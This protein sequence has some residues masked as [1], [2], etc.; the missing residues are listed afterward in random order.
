MLQSIRRILLWYLQQRSMEDNLGACKI[1]SLSSEG[2]GIGEFEGAAI[3]VPFTLPGE[4][5]SFQQFGSKRR[6]KFVFQSVLQPSNLRIEPVCKHFTHCGGCTLQHM[7]SSLYSEFKKSLITIP[8]QDQGLDPFIVR[9]IV[10]L[11]FGQRR[12]SNIEAIKK[13]DTVFLG[14]HRWRGH[15]IV[16]LTECHTLSPHLRNLL[17]PLR[18][19]LTELLEP[20]QKAKIFLTQTKVGV[21]LSLEIQG[22]LQLNDGQ[23]ET[24]KNFGLDQNLARLIFKHG[25]KIDLLYQL[26][27]PV[28]EF[29]GVE[30]AV[31]AYGF[32][33]ATEEADRVLSKFVVEAIPAGVQKIADLFCG[34]GTF[35]FPLSCISPVDAYEFDKASLLALEQAVVKS[36]REVTTVH[37]NLYDHPLTKAELDIYD[38]VV[39][40]PPRAG[41]L[42]QIKHLGQSSVRTV[43]YV[44][45]GPQSFARDAKELVNSGYMLQSITPVDQFAWAAHL[46]VIGVFV[47]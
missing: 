28:I 38:A 34:R 11:P 15:Q 20:F 6:K 42:E 5:V 24:L 21:D 14:F 23:R 44:S 36:G 27:E 47:R 7:Q 43:V 9:D 19:V 18:V 41:A 46:E 4:Q 1:Y 10:T 31:D 32:L 17:D 8:L 13:G 35:S 37:R 2:E 40:D 12:R 26:A 22:V 25:K 33:Q 45:C 3:K 30:V 29:D 16:N 39:I